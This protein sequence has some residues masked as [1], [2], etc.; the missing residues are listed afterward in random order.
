M[1]AGQ[2][3]EWKESEAV[4]SP[5]QPKKAKRSSRASAPE[6]RG[7]DKDY[8]KFLGDAPQMPPADSELEEIF[9]RHEDP[10]VKSSKVSFLNILEPDGRTYEAFDVIVERMRGW[11]G[12]S[13]ENTDP[14]HQLEF[15]P[16]PYEHGSC[17]GRSLH[18]YALELCLTCY[19]QQRWPRNG[20]RNRIGSGIDDS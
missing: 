13:G 8:L 17:P 10:K 2:A 9:R 18:A 5:R 1:T 3:V 15:D 20:G 11:C 12:P 4:E 6:G 19:L 16:D 14:D 7:V